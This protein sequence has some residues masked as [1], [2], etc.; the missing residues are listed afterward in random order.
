MSDHG[1]D[2]KDSKPVHTYMMNG[3]VISCNLALG[4][5]PRTAAVTFVPIQ[6]KTKPCSAVLSGTRLHNKHIVWR[7]VCWFPTG[8]KRA[9]SE[10]DPPGTQI[11]QVVGWRHQVSREV[12]GERGQSDEQMA[13]GLPHRASRDYM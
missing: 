9:D 3:P 4:Y 13:H 2:A 10:V 12:G 1:H 7:D 11:G 5:I 6:K 8:E